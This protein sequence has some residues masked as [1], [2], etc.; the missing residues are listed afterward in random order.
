[1]NEEENKKDGTVSLL[2]EKAKNKQIDATMVSPNAKNRRFIGVICILISAFCFSLMSVFVRLAGDAPTFQKALFRNSVASLVSFCLLLKSGSFKIKKG[3]LSLLLFRSISGTIGILG[4]FY[5]IDYL[6]NLSDAAILNKLAPFFSIIFSVWI[7]NE[8]ASAKD[9]LLVLTAFIGAIFIIKP[10]AD[11]AKNAASLI[12]VLGG[13]GAGIAYT[14]VRKLGMRGERAP[15]I[16]FYFSVFS[17]LCVLP[18]AIAQWQSL[19]FTQVL[20]LLLAGISASGAQFSVTLAYKFAPAKEISVF[21]YSQVLFS[22]ILGILFFT[23]IPDLFSI[24][25]Y[26]IIIGAAFVKWLLSRKKSNWVFLM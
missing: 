17:S 24:L 6:T 4:N 21:D 22:A 1:M 10:S 16:V 13:L 20:F 3:N 11:I 7:L 23:D 9:W 14:F 8:K 25:G 19:H 15:V 5:A 18:M 26:L 2:S 12:G